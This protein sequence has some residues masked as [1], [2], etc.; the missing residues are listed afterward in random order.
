MIRLTRR[1][2]CHIFSKCVSHWIWLK[3]T[4]SYISARCPFAGLVT[5]VFFNYV[6]LSLVFNE[7]LYGRNQLIW[8]WLTL[9]EIL[10]F[11][12]QI[13]DSSPHGYLWKSNER[14]P[15]SWLSHLSSPGRN[16]GAWQ[17]LHFPPSRPNGAGKFKDFV[18]SSYVKL[19]CF[20]LIPTQ[21]VKSGRN[22]GVLLS[23][24]AT[25]WFLFRM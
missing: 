16:C 25:L 2:I 20:L 17:L 21:T 24:I 14:V 12:T 19:R 10:S 8:G 9:T 7:I 1:S 22:N 4:L 13:F 23:T 18:G 6:F 3:A 5:I 15:G 11:Q